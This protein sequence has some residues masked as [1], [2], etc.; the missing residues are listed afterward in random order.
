MFNLISI[1]T[2]PSSSH[3]L[4]QQMVLIESIPFYVAINTP[5]KYLIR[6]NRDKKVGLKVDIIHLVE[7]LEG[8][9]IRRFI[10]NLH[11]E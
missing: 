1:H 9:T 3:K 5:L 6:F 4:F 8:I 2:E 10:S 7:S 11:K